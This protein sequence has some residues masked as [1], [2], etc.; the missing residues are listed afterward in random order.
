MSNRHRKAPPV[1]REGREPGIDKG[2]CTVSAR[3]VELPCSV[4]VA[5]VMEGR[6]GGGGGEKQ[7]AP[8]VALHPWVRSYR[9]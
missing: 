8:K 1:A 5:H 6:G 9:S 4:L 3:P 2:V 7:A